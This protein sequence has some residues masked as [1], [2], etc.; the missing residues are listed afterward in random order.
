MRKSSISVINCSL[1]TLQGANFPKR[2]YTHITKTAAFGG[3][4]RHLSIDA[5]LGV[6]TLPHVHK[7]SVGID[8]KGRASVLSCVLCTVAHHAH[9]RTAKTTTITTTKITHLILPVSTTEK[10][11]CLDVLVV[12]IKNPTRTKRVANVSTGGGGGC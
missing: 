12:P 9:Y 7:I 5:S 10:N 4:P 11:E 1:P 3:S 2:G 8:A 6:S